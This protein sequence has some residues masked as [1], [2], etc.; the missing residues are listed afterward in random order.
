MNFYILSL[1]KDADEGI[2]Q[3]ITMLVGGITLVDSAAAHLH[4]AKDDCVT[5]YLS[6]HVGRRAWGQET[7]QSMRK[8][9]GERQGI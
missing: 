1:T 9:S 4:R 2:G 3:E 6:A 8:R 7:R 5:Q